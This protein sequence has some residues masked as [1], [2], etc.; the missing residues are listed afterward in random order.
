MFRQGGADAWREGYAAACRDAGLPV[1]EMATDPAKKQVTFYIKKVDRQR[2]K[3]AYQ[4][5]S[6]QEN[7]RSWSDFVAQALI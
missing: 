1:R 2:A 6:S 5:T 7:D 3:A 4:A